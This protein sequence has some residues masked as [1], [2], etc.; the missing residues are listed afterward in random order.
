[1]PGGEIA[2]K[3][4]VVRIAIAV[5]VFVVVKVGARYIGNVF[6]VVV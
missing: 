6:I 1:M 3:K 4:A 5:A 2:S